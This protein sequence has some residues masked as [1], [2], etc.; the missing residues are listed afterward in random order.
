[1]FREQGKKESQRRTGWGIRLL[2]CHWYS[3]ECEESTEGKGSWVLKEDEIIDQER[4]DAFE[5]DD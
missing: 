1:M 3:G 5:C 2:S 4:L